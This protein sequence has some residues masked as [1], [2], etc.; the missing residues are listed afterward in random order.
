VR[1]V[2]ARFCDLGSGY[3]ASRIDTGRNHTC[4]RCRAPG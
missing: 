1:V 4:R 2:A 3:H